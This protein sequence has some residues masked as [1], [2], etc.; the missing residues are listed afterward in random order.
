MK[1]MDSQ[2]HFISHAADIKGV[3]SRVKTGF[4]HAGTTETEQ[5]ASRSLQECIWELL[6][7]KIASINN[8]TT[9]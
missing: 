8:V 7:K 3:Q 4:V 9:F 2:E 5:F 1:T 6:S